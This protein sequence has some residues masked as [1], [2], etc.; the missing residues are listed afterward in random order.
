MN[1]HENPALPPENPGR[2]ASA[3]DW[4]RPSVVALILA[5]LIPLFGVFVWRWEVFPLLLLFW[6]ENVI[7]GALNALKMLL[8]SPDEPPVWVVKLF[9]VPFFC[10][11]YGMFTFVHGVFVM[12]F[13]GGA[14]RAGAPFPD[15]ASFWRTACELKLQWAILGLAVSHAVSFVTNYLGHGEYRRASLPLLMQQPYGR[16]V[17]LHLTIL[18]GGFLMIALKSPIA[19]LALLVVLKIALDLRGHLRERRK[20]A[21]RGQGSR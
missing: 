21:A 9:L 19:G 3:A 13:F 18:L 12:G 17:V 10:F 14:F 2:E 6:S 4:T 11:H 8:A 16:I 7:I 1:P 15:P 5:N 20:L